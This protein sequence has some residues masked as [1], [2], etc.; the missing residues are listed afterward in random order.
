[1]LYYR[2]VAGFLPQETWDFKVMLPTDSAPNTQRTA[3]DR[4]TL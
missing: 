2:E 3:K 1:M 4:N